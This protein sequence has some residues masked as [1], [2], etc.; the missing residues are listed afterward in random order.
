MDFYWL[1]IWNYNQNDRKL[2]CHNKWQLQQQ[3]LKPQSNIFHPLHFS[4]KRLMNKLW[5][6]QIAKIRSTLNHYRDH[7]KLYLYIFS[8]WLPFT[9]IIGNVVV[10]VVITQKKNAE[11]EKEKKNRKKWQQQELWLKVWK[12]A[13]NRKKWEYEVWGIEMMREV[14]WKRNFR[15]QFLYLEHNFEDISTRVSSEKSMREKFNYMNLHFS[16]YAN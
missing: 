8:A 15:L 1:S 6:F 5:L 2:F 13:S 16:M 12:M 11:W 3:R 4:I 7:Y 14:K 10:F 9:N